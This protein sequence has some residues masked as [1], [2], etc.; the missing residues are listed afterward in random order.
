MGKPLSSLFQT[1]AVSFQ[2]ISVAL[3]GPLPGPWKEPMQVK[4]PE[5]LSFIG[6]MVNAPLLL[7]KTVERGHW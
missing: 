2:G 3:L 6:F 5:S 1:R 7:G 4:G